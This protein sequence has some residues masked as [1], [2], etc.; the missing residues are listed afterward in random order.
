MNSYRLPSHQFNSLPSS[1]L[2]YAGRRLASTLAA[3]S[4]IGG[5]V[6]VS[7]LDGAGV[8]TAIAVALGAALF[9]A[10]AML[11]TNLVRDASVRAA[12]ARRD[13]TNH[14]VADVDWESLD[15]WGSRSQLGPDP[16]LVI[17]RET[18]ARA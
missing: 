5:I 16:E 4:A 6:A 14:R 13:A 8:P 15:A 7:L 3:V 12:E 9:V 18:G 10:A 17:A 2:V 11:G 1:P